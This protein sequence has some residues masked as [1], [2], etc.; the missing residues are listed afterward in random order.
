MSW[1]TDNPFLRLSKPGRTP[2]FVDETLY[3]DE[4]GPPPPMV[5]PAPPPIQKIATKRLPDIPVDSRPGG[6]KGALREVAGGLVGGWAPR[7]GE[8]I[9]QGDYPSKMR[10]YGRQVG[11]IKAEADIDSDIAR[12]EASRASAGASVSSG[13]AAEARRKAE[14]ARANSFGRKPITVNKNERLYDPRVGKVLL[15]SEKEPDEMIEIDPEA[16]KRLG[17]PV[18]PDGKIKIPKQAITGYFNANKPPD[19]PTE[20]RAIRTEVAGANPGLTKEQV[21]AKVAEALGAERKGKG[22]LRQAQ[23]A[24]A[25]RGPAPRGGDQASAAEDIASAIQEGKQDF[26]GLTATEKKLVRPVLTKKGWTE[27][28][29]YSE[30]EKTALTALDRLDQLTSQLEP[31]YTSGR[32]A[33]GTGVIAGRLPSVAVSQEG[34]DVRS[35]IADMNS[36]MMLIRSGKAV[37]PSEMQRIEKFIPV[38]TDPDSVIASKLKNFRAA[39]ATARASIGKYAKGGKATEASVAETVQMRSPSGKVGPV[40]RERV[41]AAKAAGYEVVK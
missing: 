23:I 30:S 32:G 9:A 21:D 15:E 2:N 39:L 28:P 20:V 40:S 14:E 13:R 26:H 34:K 24:R 7:A 29:A 8:R 16:G 5:D 35:M 17:L 1:L 37:T 41:E 38:E 12:A 3:E 25:R 33:P 27:P 11:Q 10:E 36:T 4:P 19:E 18:G 6:V 22:E 31:M